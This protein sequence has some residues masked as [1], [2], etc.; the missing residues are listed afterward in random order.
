MSSRRRRPRFLGSL[1][2]VTMPGLVRLDVLRLAGGPSA[3]RGGRKL[4]RRKRSVG[5]AHYGNDGRL[6]NTRRAKR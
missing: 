2:R 5:W 1:H 3:G 4:A 6:H